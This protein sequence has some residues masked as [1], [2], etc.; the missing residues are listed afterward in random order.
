MV[1][2]TLDYYSLY[3]CDNDKRVTERVEWKY[4]DFKH[5]DK[6]LIRLYIEWNNSH[7]LRLFFTTI[8]VD[9]QRV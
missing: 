9:S 7:Y 5:R 1:G 3:Q 4:N 8:A 2:D 6:L